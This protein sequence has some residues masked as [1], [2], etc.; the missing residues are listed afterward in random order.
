MTMTSYP[1][2]AMPS[3]LPVRRRRTRASAA[4]HLVRPGPVLDDVD[5]R[6]A[7]GQESM[8]PSAS[9]VVTTEDRMRLTDRIALVTGGASG[10]GLATAERFLEEGARV[11]IADIARERGEAAAAGLEAGGHRGVSAIACDVSRGDQVERLVEGVLTAHGRIDILFNN[12]GV[13]V[14]H[15]VHEIPEEEW[16]G[17]LAV[18]LTSVYLVSKHVVPG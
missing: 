7:R 2:L 18:N 5:Y 9:D 16:A 12:A 11:V 15:E 3:P 17:I 14:P 1:L 4:Y 8:D 13:F 10:I 6:L